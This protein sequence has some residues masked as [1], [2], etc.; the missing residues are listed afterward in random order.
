MATVVIKCGASVTWR[1]SDVRTVSVLVFHHQYFP[2]QQQ[3]WICVIN[4]EFLQTVNASFRLRH[5][6]KLILFLD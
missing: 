3:V 2:Q 5:L 6:E 1:P 4:P